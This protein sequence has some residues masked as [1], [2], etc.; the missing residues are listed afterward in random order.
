MPDTAES[1]IR[2][3][4]SVIMQLKDEVITKLLGK[5][6][7]SSVEV[8]QIR[9][10]LDGLK[11]DELTAQLKEILGNHA[12]WAA[13]KGI[14][15]IDDALGGKSISE[16]LNVAPTAI[17][18]AKSYDPSPITTIMPELLNN[19]R[20]QVNLSF[21]GQKTPAQVAKTITERFG[22]SAR[23]AETIVRTEGKRLQNFGAQARI[24]DVGVKA[25]TLGI[26]MVKYWIHSSGKGG[27]AGPVTLG[28]TKR[29]GFAKGKVRQGYEPRAHH[30]AMHGV[31][32]PAP[33]G[34]FELH[35]LKT[36]EGWKITGPHDPKLP[37]EEVINCFP[38]ETLV[39][40]RRIKRA[41]R[42]LY[43]GQFVT[44][45]TALGNK[46]TGTP[47][48]PIATPDGF[49][50]LGRLHEGGHVLSCKLGEGMTSGDPDV[51]YIPASIEQVFDSLAVMFRSERIPFGRVDFYGDTPDGEVDVVSA[52]RDLRGR[53]VSELAEP[54][55]KLDFAVTDVLQGSLL[56]DGP[57]LQFVSASLHS[58]DSVMGGFGLSRSLLG[59]HPVVPF[60]DDFGMAPELNPD[61]RETRRE[62]S[63]A[64]SG[65]FR[66]FIHGHPVDVPEFESGVTIIS[67]I[68]SRGPRFD[69][70]ISR[71]VHDV[72]SVPVFTFETESGI[73]NAAGIIARN[74]YCDVSARIDRERLADV[75][76]PTPTPTVPEPAKSPSEI[77][78]PARPPSA[79]I[80]TPSP[81]IESMRNTAIPSVTESIGKVSPNMEKIYTR[82][83]NAIDKVHS[84]PQAARKVPVSNS[85]AKNCWGSFET[86]FAGTRGKIGVD[87]NCPDKSF[88][89]THEMGHMFDLFGLG[90]SG[91]GGLDEAKYG[92]SM[93]FS[94]PLF[95]AI[96]SS[97]TYQRLSGIKG[98]TKVS[99]GMNEKGKEII[100]TI[101]ASELKYLKGR[102]ELFAR[103]Y[104]QYIAT[105]S[106]DPV[107]LRQLK[108]V[109]SL[110]EGMDPPMQWGNKEFEPIR[111]AFNLLLKSK[112]LRK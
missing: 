105:E 6:S 102:D 14:G 68:R 84:M 41:F 13:D 25:Q 71:I 53:I 31:T 112:G 74:C 23:H 33:D 96:F 18:V 66:H 46:L 27:K 64:V 51:D 58:P 2:Q 88:T 93:G 26:Q 73:Y 56:G 9:K 89:L 65:D 54:V 30:K 70:V 78:S 49:V 75:K 38:G 91:K 109:Q 59:R 67:P 100:H 110:D 17:D 11:G 83:S 77:P 82:V 3:A 97:P 63:P 34:L 28:A 5:D 79:P 69:F 16:I 32:V 60:A 95:D 45:T 92:S 62:S 52:L 7:L 81:S 50:P 99:W 1:A 20:N 107:L 104:A 103:A 37:A 21:L 61:S 35:N 55:G 87:P 8:Q 86:D 106:Q 85:A 108:A 4:Y 47:N 94:K 80:P 57:A 19:V 29:K 72:C 43:S 101:E 111:N 36:G 44:I 98:G 39:D 40:A 90:K 24:K 15:M 22:V 10:V 12:A 42:S 48:H 76:Q